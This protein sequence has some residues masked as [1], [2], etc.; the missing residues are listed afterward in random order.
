MKKSLVEGIRFAEDLRY[1]EFLKNKNFI[2]KVTDRIIEEGVGLAVDRE[3]RN[4]S[5]RITREIG[6]DFSNLLEKVKKSLAISVDV[7][8][9]IKKEGEI[10]AFCIK[11]SAENYVVCLTGSLVEH[12]DTAQIEF[13]LGHELGHAV[14]DHHLLPIHNIISETDDPELEDVED[15]LRWS[16]MAEISADRAGLI[17]CNDLSA[18]VGAMLVLTTGISSSLLKI[19]TEKYVDYSRELVGAVDIGREVEDF[20]NTHPFNPLRVVALAE[21]WRFWGDAKSHEGEATQGISAA[22]QEVKLILEKMEGE[23][24]LSTKI[25]EPDR[26]YERKKSGIDDATSQALFWGSVSVAC[27]DK[28]FS[29][30]ESQTIGRWLFEGDVAVELNRLKLQKDVNSYSFSRF[31]AYVAEVSATPTANRCA[32][33]QKLVVVARADG[34]VCDREKEMLETISKKLK[35]SPKFYEK[36][37]K[38]L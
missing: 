28:E 13:V 37:L 32:I 33:L 1:F 6:T 3:F 25:S 14:Y 5:L 27:A 38:Y 26:Q 23:F 22:D 17:A 8:L 7:D 12:M 31:E 2:R 11:E 35:I 29:D 16:R 18:A 20:Y 19:K 9:Y 15:L 4:S 24:T 34:L 21:F 10:N 36:I 30:V